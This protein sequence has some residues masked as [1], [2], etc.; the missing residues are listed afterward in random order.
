M[1][2]PEQANAE[3]AGKLNAEDCDEIPLITICWFN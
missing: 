1:A 2:L 3:L